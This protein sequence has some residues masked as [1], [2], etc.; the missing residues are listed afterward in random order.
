MI[1][2]ILLGIMVGWGVYT[3]IEPER[4][5]KMADG[6]RMQVRRLAAS[7]VWD[8]LTTRA[9]FGD[10]ECNKETKLNGGFFLE[11]MKISWKRAE[12]AKMENG[13]YGNPE[14]VGANGS[15]ND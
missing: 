2:L 13:R 12:W 8:G 7:F 1:G 14:R 11:N 5:L 4:R 3:R 6:A 15:G 10:R 9:F